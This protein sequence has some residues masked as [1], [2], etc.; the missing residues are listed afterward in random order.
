MP[1]KLVVIIL[2]ALSLSIS[3]AWGTEPP[4]TAFDRLGSLAH[5]ELVWHYFSPTLKLLGGAGLAFGGKV[6]FDGGTG[7]GQ[8][9]TVPC[10][11]FLAVPGTIMFAQGVYDTIFSPREFDDEYRQLKRL[12]ETERESAALAYIKTRAEQDR[13][14][15]QPTLWNGFSLFRLPV[16]PAEREYNAYLNERGGPPLNK[17]MGN[18]Q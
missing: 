16:S 18:K 6:V 14:S 9:V 5:E 1:N 13:Q 17:A 2:L 4:R 15:R 10:A 3:G 12:G 7:W 11:A 8:I